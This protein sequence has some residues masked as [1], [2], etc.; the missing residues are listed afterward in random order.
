MYF[1]FANILKTYAQSFNILH[2]S[3]TLVTSLLIIQH[4]NLDLPNRKKWY[5]INALN[6]KSI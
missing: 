1:V 3:S 5:H 6:C 4:F 2:I